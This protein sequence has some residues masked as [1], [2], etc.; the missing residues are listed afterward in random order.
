M[1]WLM[2]VLRLIHVGGGALWVGM[3]AF[4][5]FFLSPALAEAGPQE[6]GKLMAALQKQRI[7]IIMPVIALLTIGSGLWLMV[8]V[9]GGPG[10]LA[11]SRTGM[12]LNLG[13]AAAILAF[14]IGIVFMRPLMIARHNGHRSR[15]GSALAGARRDAEPRRRAP[16]AVRVGRDG[17][18]PLPL[19]LR[20]SCHRPLG[21]V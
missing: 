1:N 13:A 16:V 4:M 20:F 6:S 5:T 10:A 8:R 15:G 18:G 2:L 19:T 21:R 9:Y 11:A 17:G 3:M 12:A 14:V 7:M